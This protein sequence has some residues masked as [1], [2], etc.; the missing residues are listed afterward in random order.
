MPPPAYLHHQPAD[1]GRQGVWDAKAAPPHDLQQLA[2]G[3]RV[4]PREPIRD[5]RATRDGEPP[6]RVTD[7]VAQHAR[8]LML[9]LE[10]CGVQPDRPITMDD[11][12]GIPVPE[13][14]WG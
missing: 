10:G 3:V 4:A 13:A 2:R 9:M 6:V 7:H 14:A 11:L 5:R 12:Q 1:G 8:Q